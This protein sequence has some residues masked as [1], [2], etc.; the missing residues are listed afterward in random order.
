MWLGHHTSNF[1]FS[2][3]MKKTRSKKPLNKFWTP[4]LSKPI[5]SSRI[6]NHSDYSL[7]QHEF[8]LLRL[9]LKHILPSS[10]PSSP[11]LLKE[12]DSLSRTLRLRHFFKD[13]DNP[14]L[15][16]F[17]LPNPTWQPPTKYTPLEN[18]IAKHQTI[19]RDTLHTVKLKSSR[20]AP[21]LSLAL[22]SLNNN[23][24]IIILPADKNV[25]VCVVNKDTYCNK[26]NNRTPFRC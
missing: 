20:I 4:L 10:P 2:P 24:R 22:Q 9:G 17:R 5:I 14:P 7:S 18:I 6:H 3:Y 11:I 1:P 15:N 8:Q 23:R 16:P 19:F 21:H 12:F 25:G 26:A 13:V